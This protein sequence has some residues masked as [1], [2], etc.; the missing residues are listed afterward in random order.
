[1]K[2]ILLSAGCMVLMSSVA[3][4]QNAAPQHERGQGMTKAQFMAK[5]QERAEKMFAKTDA[6]GDGTVTREEMKAVRGQMKGERGKRGEH[7][8]GQRPD[9]GGA[10]DG[11][12][13]NLFP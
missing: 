3:M 8:G 2:K 12:E 11:G 1:M 4:A 9:G 13:S 7:G 10:N 5:S 6:N